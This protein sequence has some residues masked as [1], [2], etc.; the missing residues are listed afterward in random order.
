M[1]YLAGLNDAQKEAVLTT[2]GPLLV[3]AGA[4]S[5]KTR[6]ITHRILHLIRQGVAPDNILAVTFTNKAAKEMRERIA[7]LIQKDAA[8]DASIRDGSEH[9]PIYGSGRRFPVTTTFHSF[10]VRVIR[11]HH[12]VLGLKKHFSIYDRN[13]TMRAIKQAMEQADYSTKEHEPKNIL[14]SISR[15]KGDGLTPEEYLADAKSYGA[16]AAG[17]VWGH[18]E[19]ILRENDALDFDDLLVKTRDLL[20]QHA[21]ILEAYRNRYRY[22]HVDEFQDT[23]AIQMDILKLLAAH[24]NVCVVG[25]V[26]QSIYS[27]RGAQIKNL[28]QFEKFFPATK[29]IKLEENYR[30][31]KVIIDASNAII[32]KNLNRPEKT[33]FTNNVEGEP[34]ICTVAENEKTEA[35]AVATKIKDLI[36]T[37]AR[38]SDFAIIYRTNSQSR[39]LEEAM[40]HSSVAYQV[41]GTKFFER[42]EVKDTLAYLRYALSGTTGDLA[43]IINVPSRGIGKVS[44]LKIMEGKREELTGKA[45]AALAQFDAMVAEIAAAAKERPVSETLRLIIEKSGMEGSFRADGEEGAERLANVH[46]LVSLATKFNDLP[47]DDAVQQL[48]EEAALQSDQDELAEKET[49]DAVRLMTIHAS[50][51][52][53]F[54][55]VFITGLEQGLFPH[56]GFDTGS[57]KRDTEEERRLFYVALTRAQKQIFL[58]MAQSRMIFGSTRWNEPS[59][60]LSD[61]PEALMVHDAPPPRSGGGKKG[62]LLDDWE[63]E[64]TIWL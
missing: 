50:K 12:E 7:A 23:N 19:R 32:E 29:I 21:D 53:E 54:P 22:I 35:A 42:A 51:G 43:R 46:E 57:S 37:G 15:A 24:G 18:Y 36:K 40:L 49:F 14:G 47:A 45:A 1:D 27:W 9:S 3:L 56:E 59:P 63:G 8:G 6:V 13:D 16:R 62:G 10:G 33:V 55:Y 30:S 38:P 58:S 5:G 11:E 34:I 48:L 39:T 41:L 26:D 20:A 64:S 60:F 25:D 28:L 4:G 61:I 44:L 17:T 52:L 31:T 2:E